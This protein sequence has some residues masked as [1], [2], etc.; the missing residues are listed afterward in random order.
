LLIN[1]QFITSINSFY[2]SFKTSVNKTYLKNSIIDELAIKFIKK[3][4]KI[5]QKYGNMNIN[6]RRN[7]NEF[8][9]TTEI[10]L[11]KNYYFFAQN[12]LINYIIYQPDNIFNKYISEI[13]KSLQTT[14]ESLMNDRNDKYSILIRKHLENCFKKKLKSFSNKNDIKINIDFNEQEDNIIFS[15]N[16]PI[17]SQQDT[18][19]TYSAI[20]D[21][22]EIPYQ[23]TNY[24]SFNKEIISELEIKRKIITYNNWFTFNK[25]NKKFLNEETVKK[26]EKF[27]EKINYQQS[28]FD[29]NYNDETF[30]LFQN[31]IKK[32]L[33]NVLSA[34]APKF[35]KEIYLKYENNII[36]KI[37]EN[38]EIEKIIKN[39]DIQSLFK[40]LIF[41]HFSENTKTEKL[42]KLNK[43]SIILTGKSGVGKSTL[44]NCL[45]KDKKAKEGDFKVITL[46]TQ[47]YQSDKI[48]FLNLIDTRGYELN[49]KYD[50]QKIKEEIIKNIKLNKERKDHNEHIQCIWFCLNGNSI[51]ES[52]IK[53]LN[54]LK[55]NEFNIPLVVIFTKAQI[56][57]VVEKMEKEINEKFPDLNFVPVLGRRT[58]V[59]KEFG[60]DDL[61]KKTIKA[62]N[63]KDKNGIFDSVFKV[64]K[65]K[66]E[67]N[68]K[69]TLLEIQTDII[70]KLTEEYITDY[71]SYL[72]EYDLE[73]YIYRLIEK[74]IMGFSFQ[75][76][77]TE[78]TLNLDENTK[79]DIKNQIENLIKMYTEISE[80]YIN[81][82][83]NNKSLDY[84][85]LQVNVERFYN[86]SITPELK[87]NRKD[88]QRL[89]STSL[90]ENYYFIAQKY[91]FYRLIHDLLIILT[92]QFKNNIFKKMQ[93]FLEEDE[94]IKEYCR[95]ISIKIFEDF[96]EDIDK[97]KNNNGKIYS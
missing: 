23:N 3:Q 25:K 74:S 75:N 26:I 79:N 4:A 59:M 7:L 16:I 67:N 96:E 86:S 42:I 5:E 29:N 88:F 61:I 57:N 77:I 17:F 65:E 2:S 32:D 71:T 68:L 76:D 22:F 87:R 33:I 6:N 95:N 43:I 92:E 15:E 49:Q 66:E 91:S 1:S 84:L 31:E 62:I 10:F 46:A 35:L 21:N 85:D 28:D 80:K 60:L 37:L 20:N 12:F 48:P 38:D 72:N 14:I 50:P 94:E 9:K 52:E 56:K 93:N 8:K 70:N 45:L 24:F 73:Q 34:N 81:Q 51:D 30:I 39:E 27:I 54:D 41:K 82:L 53:T 55:N 11:K 63:S 78:N 64:Y 40:N 18:L 89:I 97:Y 83:L 47:S 69:T 90:R 19:A 44:I 36:L 58:E 13:Y